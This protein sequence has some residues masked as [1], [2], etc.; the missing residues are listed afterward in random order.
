MNFSAKEKSMYRKVVTNNLYRPQ[1]RR[2]ST[3]VPVQK[4]D[5]DSEI[6]TEK[7]E[8]NSPGKKS[9]NGRSSRWTKLSLVFTA[10]NRFRN[11]N[12]V[13]INS[14]VYYSLILFTFQKNLRETMR[15]S[16]Y[17]PNRYSISPRSK[18]L[19]VSV[20]NTIDIE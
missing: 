4:D 15:D 13:R 9:Q 8:E 7:T 6:A 2:I 19:V 5:E 11:T 1:L 18:L 14:A 16:L 12:V 20:R 3:D 17:V 10:T